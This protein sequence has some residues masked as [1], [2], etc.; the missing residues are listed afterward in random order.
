[1]LYVQVRHYWRWA[2]CLRPGTW[3]TISRWKS[4]GRPHTK[5]RTRRRRR[6]TTHW[7]SAGAPTTYRAVPSRFTSRRPTTHVAR[8]RPRSTMTFLHGTHTH[9]IV[10]LHWR[11]LVLALPPT[12]F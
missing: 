9:I 7:W 5:C 2:W 4:S 12:P 11:H 3:W 6:E 10:L 8:R 1:M